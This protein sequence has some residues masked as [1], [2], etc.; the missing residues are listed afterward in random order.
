MYVWSMHGESQQMEAALTGLRQ[1]LLF[2]VAARPV[3][4]TSK[5]CP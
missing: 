1:M 4:G 3:S 2:C 5:A